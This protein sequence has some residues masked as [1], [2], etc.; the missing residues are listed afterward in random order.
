[1]GLADPA[2]GAALLDGAEEA[3]RKKEKVDDLIECLDKN[4]K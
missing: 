2:F 4:G 3:G 1:M